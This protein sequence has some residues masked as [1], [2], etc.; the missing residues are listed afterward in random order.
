MI[1][2]GYV[3]INIWPVVIR[4]IAV[5]LL[6]GRN[7]DR[8]MSCRQ[9]QGCKSRLLYLRQVDCGR[10]CSSQRRQADEIINAS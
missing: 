4:Q 8:R 5:E 1:A 3:I 9:T 10:P 2:I 7:G 6:N